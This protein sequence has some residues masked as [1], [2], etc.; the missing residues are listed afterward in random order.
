MRFVLRASCHITTSKVILSSSRHLQ[1][2]HPSAQTRGQGFAKHDGTI[3]LWT[4]IEDGCL[5]VRVWEGEYVGTPRS[6]FHRAHVFPFVV[7]DDKVE[8]SSCDDAEAQIEFAMVSGNYRLLVGQRNKTRHDDLEQSDVDL[9]FQRVESLP[10]ASEILVADIDL[11][12]QYPL[13]EWSGP[14]A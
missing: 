8:V 13:E 3:V 10:T 5:D 4:I 9:V 6:A 14:N 12:P 11:A 7:E 2:P 1:F